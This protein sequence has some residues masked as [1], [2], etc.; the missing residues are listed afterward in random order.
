MAR[1]P[2]SIALRPPGA[3]QEKRGRKQ[4]YSMQQLM[5]VWLYVQEGMARTGLSAFQFCRKGEFNWL[6][7]GRLLPPYQASKQTGRL[8]IG[9]AAHGETLRR[10]YQE[11]VAVLQAESE[12][13]R[14]FQEMGLRSRVFSAQSPI[15]EWWRREL[16]AR[17][18]GT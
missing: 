12:T 15:E 10:R 11:A 16:Q 6:V 3:R 8:V 2:Y 4:R 13:C 17:I 9:H 18:G 14:R 5:D 7:A 1:R